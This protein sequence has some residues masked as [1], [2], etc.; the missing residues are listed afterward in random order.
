M[1]EEGQTVLTQ[2]VRKSRT[3]AGAERHAQ[4]SDTSS[5]PEGSASPIGMRQLKTHEGA[6]WTAARAV[7]V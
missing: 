7:I 3:S 4:S 6:D 2:S 5:Q 1:L